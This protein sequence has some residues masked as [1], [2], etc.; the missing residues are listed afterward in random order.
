MN[1]ESPGTQARKKAVWIM[2]NLT[3]DASIAKQMYSDVRANAF[4]KVVNE[5]TIGSE[6]KKM[7]LWLLANLTVDETNRSQLY[8]DDLLMV[9]CT[10]K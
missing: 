1:E 6:V 4:I 8:S 5:E 3:A 7:T 9:Y 2:A 10:A